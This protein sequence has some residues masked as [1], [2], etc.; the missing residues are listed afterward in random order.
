ML[1]KSHF[2]GR[3]RAPRGLFE[4][5]ARVWHPTSADMLQKAL[6]KQGRG[7]L[8]DD[9]ALRAASHALFAQ[10]PVGR[11]GGQALVP[12]FDRDPCFPRKCLSKLSH[13]SCG[14]TLGSVEPKW[15]S[16]DRLLN[17]F[18]DSQL[19][20][21]ANRFWQA[22][23]PDCTKRYGDEQIRLGDGQAGTDCS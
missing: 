1:Y 23:V 14:V 20:H 4:L 11:H 9:L 8:I 3:S 19:A 12:Q 7:H 21:E 10:A 16:N 5:F 15:Q 18:S 13:A 17:A 2:M 6:Q 22:G